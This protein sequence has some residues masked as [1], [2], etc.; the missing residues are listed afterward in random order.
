MLT[1]RVESR[2]RTSPL[3]GRRALSLPPSRRLVRLVLLLL[4]WMAVVPRSTDAFQLQSEPEPADST[5]LR[6]DHGS[7]VLAAHTRGAG[8]P[9]VR[10]ASV[11]MSPQLADNLALL[12]ERFE[13]NEFVVCIEGRVDAVDQL[14]LSDF[15]MPHL[16]YSH[17]TGASVHPNGDCSQYRG[18]VGTLHNHPRAY[19]KDRGGD[20]KNCYLSRVDIVSW[21]EHSS[22]SY[23]LVMCGPRTWAWW[24]RSQV[25]PDSELALPLPG[26]LYGRSESNDHPEQP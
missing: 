3:N 15:R 26:Q 2:G 7:T 10:A 8:H 6:T 18:I 16:A 23:T 17:S 13:E 12:F 9:A 24:H 19:P 11:S 21:L 22:Y 20:W 5:L 4:A 1:R 14:Q 25:D